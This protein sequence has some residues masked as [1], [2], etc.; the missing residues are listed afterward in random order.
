MIPST[1]LKYRVSQNVIKPIQV[2][3]NPG[4]KSR[5]RNTVTEY[6]RPR[7]YAGLPAVRNNTIILEVIVDRQPWI[8]SSKTTNDQCSLIGSLLVIPSIRININTI[9]NTEALAL[10]NITVEL[11]VNSP[12]K[13]WSSKSNAQNSEINTRCFNRFP[14]NAPLV[15]AHINALRSRPIW[16][17]VQ[18]QQRYSLVIGG[19]ALRN[20][21]AVVITPGIRY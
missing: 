5:S 11:I 4:L 16:Q 6:L 9:R 1:A 12:S 8:M 19:Q 14:V 2:C 15:F 7:R 21:L 3:I 10:R 13:R 18:R 20:R 17:S